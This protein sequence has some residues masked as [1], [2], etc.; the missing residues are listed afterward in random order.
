M[1]GVPGAR[2]QDDGQLHATIRY[3]GEVDGRTAEAIAEALA[4]LQARTIEAAIDGVG[5]FHDRRDRV[6]AIW[7]GLRPRE[8]LEA[9]H[10]KVD[11]ALVR[12]GLEPERR[13][14]LPHITLARLSGSDDAA[15]FLAQHAALAS[16][17]F[18]MATLTLFESH[19]G[20]EGAI[21]EAVAEYP[22]A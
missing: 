2:W 5:V 13:A 8:P 1:G 10:N 19:L 9:L 3:I 11:R 14:Y 18:R 16:P 12:L 15:G 17:R 6:N 21:Y 20:G 7:A 4:G 22:L